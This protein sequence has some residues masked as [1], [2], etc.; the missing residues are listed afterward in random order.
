MKLIFDSEI[1]SKIVFLT[2][3][4]HTVLQGIK[5]SFQDAYQNVEIYRI[6][7]DPIRIPKLAPHYSQDIPN[8]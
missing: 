4:Y 3:L 2:F 1:K 6:L 8:F 5:K 7:P